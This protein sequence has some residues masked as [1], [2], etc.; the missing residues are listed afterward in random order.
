MVNTIFTIGYTGFQVN[1]FIR[2]LKKNKISAIIDV[3]S[4]P[5]SQYYIDFN[6]ENISSLLEHYNIYYRNY[7]L[8]FGARQKEK[9]YYPNGYLD[10]NLFSK[11]EQFLSGIKKLE[12]GMEQ[13]YTFALMCSEKDP[14]M[15]HRA[16]LVSR[17]FSLL[18]YNIIHLLP[19]NKIMTQIDIEKRL[20]DKF[21]PDR[22]QINMFLENFSTQ[23]YINEAY[24]KQNA[25][26]G[27][28]I[29]E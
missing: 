7:A 24:K 8:E 11:S 6:K 29:K 22:N 5:Y 20:L 26:I 9:K 27:Y 19:N 25:N 14:I 13:N 23:E 21:F 10:F 12:K 2:I 18:K 28:I 15:C 4:I 3:R 1:E 16:I 17:A